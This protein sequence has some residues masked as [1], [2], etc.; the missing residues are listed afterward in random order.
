MSRFLAIPALLKIAE[1]SSAGRAK[2]RTQDVLSYLD[3][4]DRTWVV[5]KGF[6]TDFAS[7]P[8]LPLMY[9]LAGD[10]AH[11]SAVLHDY[12]CTAY[13]PQMMSWRG[14]ADL[15]RE[16]MIAEGVPA[17]RRWVMYWAVR[18]FGEAKKKEE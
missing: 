4:V 8:R 14:A 1:A 15:F 7:V 2:W 10:T 3:N 6:I 17:W 12:L 18:L 13:Y 11:M 9:W 16:A 5:P